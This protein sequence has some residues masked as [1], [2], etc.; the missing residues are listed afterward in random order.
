MTTIF[1]NPNCS[2]SRRTLDLLKARGIEPQVV[3]YLRAPPSRS[4]LAELIARMGIAPR[5][6]L[7]RKEAL[8]GELGLDDP[9]WTDEQLIELMIEHPILIERPIVVTTK[10]VRLGRPPESVLEILD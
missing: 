2:T 4:E 5:A 9:K 3:E 8:Y 1:H 6:L 10:G 7:R